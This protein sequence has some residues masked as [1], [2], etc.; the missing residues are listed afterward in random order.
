MYFD[1]QFR[2]FV[3]KNYEGIRIQTGTWSIKKLLEPGTLEA[4]KLRLEH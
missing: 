2:N 3:S 4:E 1:Y